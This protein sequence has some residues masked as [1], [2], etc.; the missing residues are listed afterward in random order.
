MQA[1]QT[2]TADQNP[3]MLS[4]AEREQQFDSALSQSL[5]ALRR[6][7]VRKLHNTAGAEVDEK[8][9]ILTKATK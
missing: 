7:A 9:G 6:M 4:R 1:T 5:P 3:R 8:N 2:H